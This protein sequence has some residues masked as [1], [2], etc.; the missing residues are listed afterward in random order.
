MVRRDLLTARCTSCHFRDFHIHIDVT[1]VIKIR[2]GMDRYKGHRNCWND[3]EHQ[4]EGE[5]ETDSVLT[6]M[7]V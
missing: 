5:I 6:K 3:N 4:G 2:R 1:L 7:H